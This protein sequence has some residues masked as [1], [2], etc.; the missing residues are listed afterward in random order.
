MDLAGAS[1]VGTIHGQSLDIAVKLGGGWVPEGSASDG[2]DRGR[3]LDPKAPDSVPDISSRYEDVI[4]S[5]SA[6]CPTGC[7]DSSSQGPGI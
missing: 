6:A 3:A 1:P 7:Q 5:V 4:Y 2:P